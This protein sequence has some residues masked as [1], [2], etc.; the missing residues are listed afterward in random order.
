[1]PRSIEQFTFRLT[2]IEKRKLKRAAKIDG[3][4]LAVFVRRAALDHATCTIETDEADNGG[5]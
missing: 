5:Y 4:K 1:M 2:A 3:I